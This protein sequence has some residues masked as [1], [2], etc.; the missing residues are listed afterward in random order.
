MSAWKRSVATTLAGLSLAAYAAAGGSNEAQESLLAARAAAAPDAFQETVDVPSSGP[1]LVNTGEVKSWTFEGHVLT[2]GAQEGGGGGI[3]YAPSEAD[4]PAYRA[5]ISAAAGGATVDYF[6]ARA[7]TPSVATMLQY[8]AVYSW[9]NFAYADSVTFG[10]NLAAY[11][12]AGGTVVLGVFCTF[13]SGNSMSGTIMTAGYC[14]VVSPLGSNHFTTSTYNGGGQTCIYGGVAS[15]SSGFRDILT[16]QGTGIEDGF[17]ADGEI[18]H[19]YRG[20]TGGSQG[21]VV[22]SNGSGAVQLTS[23]GPWGTAVGNAATCGIDVS[24][25]WADIGSSLPGAGGDPVLAGVGTLAADTTN[26]LVLSNAAPSALTAVFASTSMSPQPV[27]GGTLVPGPTLVV[28]LFTTS[29]G[30]TLNL[31]FRPP[32]GLTG[33]LYAQMAVDDAGAVQGIAFSNAIE[34]TIP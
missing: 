25:A 11:N 7:S 31:T 16:V 2:V 13:T 28:R 3:L 18:C 22:Y 32:A 4:D 1:V 27:A 12:D 17:Y 21:D 23:A 26:F 24:S 30:G 14:P 9:T 29:A 15:L 10:D 20:G 6:D 33:N 5:A 19:A 34:G 8:D